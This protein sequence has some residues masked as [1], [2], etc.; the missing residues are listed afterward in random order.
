M[1][2]VTR[3]RLTSLGPVPIPGSHLH[4]GFRNRDDQHPVRVKSAPWASDP[5]SCFWEDHQINDKYELAAYYYSTSFFSFVP[6]L[7]YLCY[8]LGCSHPQRHSSVSLWG[9]WRNFFLTT[10]SRVL[11]YP[12]PCLAVR[13]CNSES[14]GVTSILGNLLAPFRPSIQPYLFRGVPRAHRLPSSHRC[15]RARAPRR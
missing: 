14:A 9:R 10:Y 12:T 2:R 4:T 5:G 13:L 7:R 3:R 11:T 1:H 6:F 15:M 8:K